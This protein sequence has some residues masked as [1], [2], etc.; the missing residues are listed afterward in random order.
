MLCCHVHLSLNI[1]AHH[2]H[3][4]ELQFN[5]IVTA[6]YLRIIVHKHKKNLTAYFTSISHIL[7]DDRCA[8]FKKE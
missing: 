6:S 7:T 5:V 1:L 2:L 3:I 8:C 4:L